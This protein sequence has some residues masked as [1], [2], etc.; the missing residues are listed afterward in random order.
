MGLIIVNKSYIQVKCSKC[1]NQVDMAIGQSILENFELTW[2]GAYKCPYCDN[3]IEL[4]GKGIPNDN[5]RE[6]ILKVDGRWGLY[7]YEDSKIEAIKLTRGV[8][9]ISLAEANN[10]L[11]AVPGIALTGT[12]T[13]MMRL[14]LFLNRKGI[15]VKT[16]RI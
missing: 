12:R 10:M 5:I 3:Q 16:K 15:N 6:T 2:W 11:K 9:R 14:E 4:D 7:V 8:L 1:N 13:E